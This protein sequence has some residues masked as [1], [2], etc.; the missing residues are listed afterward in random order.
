[1]PPPKCGEMGHFTGFL[2]QW[3]Y[4]QRRGT[5]PRFSCLGSGSLR[6]FLKRLVF[7]VKSGECAGNFCS[8]VVKFGKVDPDHTEILYFK[9]I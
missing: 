3:N 2:G 1:M 6:L 9:G 8:D 5:R 4:P 7:D